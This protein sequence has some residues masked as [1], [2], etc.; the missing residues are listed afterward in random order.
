[1]FGKSK[2]SKNYKF[3]NLRPYAWNKVVGNVKKFRTVFDRW[4]INYLSAELEFYN[5]L[6]DEKDW[7]AELSLRAYTLEDGVKT[8]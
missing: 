1:M 7:K 3:K 2:K 6:F 4:E 5:K 8:T